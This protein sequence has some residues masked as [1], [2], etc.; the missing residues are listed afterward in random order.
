MSRNLTLDLI[1]SEMNIKNISG[2]I[3]LNI[4]GKNIND[5]SILSQIPSLEI[6]SLNNNDYK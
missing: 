5:I 1:F 6:V 3:A 4:K 2:L